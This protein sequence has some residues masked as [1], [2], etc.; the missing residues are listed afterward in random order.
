VEAFHPDTIVV[1]RVESSS[2]HPRK[3]LDVKNTWS[4]GQA[5]GWCSS[6]VIV[7]QSLTRG[8]PSYDK[9]RKAI[10]R[11]CCVTRG[12]GGGGGGGG[13]VSKNRRSRPPCKSLIHKPNLAPFDLDL[14]PHT[15]LPAICDHSGASI[16]LHIQSYLRAQARHIVNL[17]MVDV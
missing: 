1:R 2:T 12:C 7:A 5:V 13:E 4:K 14:L 11:L 6:G 15:P 9:H 17:G 16:Y 8:C 3:A 10:G